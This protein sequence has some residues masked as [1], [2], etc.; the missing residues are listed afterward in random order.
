MKKENVEK[1]AADSKAV[2]AANLDFGS[3]VSDLKS[4]DPGKNSKNKVVPPA[5]KS[6][7]AADEDDQFKKFLM[8]MLFQNVVG[9]VL[10][11]AV[12]KIF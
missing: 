6:K 1:L 5:S 3:A 11:G 7:S 4:Y 2:E 12:G 8:Q 10:Q 9:P